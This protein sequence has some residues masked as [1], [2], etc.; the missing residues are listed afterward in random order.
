M[1]ILFVTDLI[2]IVEE[3]NC[4]KALIPIIK[5]LQS[6]NDVDIIRPNF[7][8]NSIIREKKVLKNGI[9]CC[10][11]LNILNLNYLTPFWGKI[12]E[13]N[14]NQYDKKIAH[15]HSG[16]LFVEQLLKHNTH[17]KPKIT[18]AVHQ[19]DIQ[20]LTNYKYSIYFKNKLLKAYKTC[21]EIACRSPHLKE[22]ILKILPEIE[23]KTVIKSSKIP[24]KLFISEKEML[25]K[26]EN[27][28]TLKFIT[29]A[30]FIKRKN[31]NLLIKAFSLHKDKNFT[32]K[33]VGSGKEEKKLKKLCNKLN[34]ENKI[35]FTG[36]LSQEKVFEEM[37]KSQIFILPSVN[38]TLGLVY[39]EASACGCLCIGTKNTGVDGVF[40]NNINSFFCDAN[41]KGIAKVLEKT[42]NLTKEDFY[43]LLKNRSIADFKSTF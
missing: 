14:I 2:P 24:E 33:I 39:L 27:I 32:L 23:D 38:E 22:K 26:F 37:R 10:N 5:E 15:R 7:L 8:P 28:S 40:Q 13:I 12:K 11:N 17:N 36:K 16:I 35:I 9:Y 21:D 41:V 31:I 29:V 19:S 43:N 18:Y 20:V 6:N 34:L 1:K 30:N 3:E 25:N 42:F 4:A